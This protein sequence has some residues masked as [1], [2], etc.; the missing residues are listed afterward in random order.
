MEAEYQISTS[1]KKGLSALCQNA[2]LAAPSTLRFP[3]DSRALSSF[4]RSNREHRS[5]PDSAYVGIGLERA[6]TEV[7]PDTTGASTQGR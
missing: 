4:I 7:P 6:F 3:T 5:S 2:C 1:A